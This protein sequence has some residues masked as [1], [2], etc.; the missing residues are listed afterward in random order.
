MNSGAHTDECP[1]NKRAIG[2]SMLARARVKTI[3][4][5]CYLPG[6]WQLQYP[7]L[8]RNS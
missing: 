5:E 3:K 4:S 6:F 1:S 7:N 8:L 2:G